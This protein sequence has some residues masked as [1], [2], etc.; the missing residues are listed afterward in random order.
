LNAE[1]RAAPAA[2]TD[3][4]PAPALEADVE[5]RPEVAVLPLES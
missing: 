2:R 3:S 5:T 4:T 1:R